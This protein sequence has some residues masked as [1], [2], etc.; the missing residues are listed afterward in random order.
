MPAAIATRVKELIRDVPGF[1]EPDVVFRDLTPVLGDPDAFKAV[2][3][4]M[5]ESLAPVKPHRVAGVEARGFLFAAP[6]ALALGAGVIPV[7]KAG[8]LPWD[9]AAVSYD[10]EYGSDTLEAHVD[11]VAPGETVAVIDDVLATGGTARAT[12]ELLEK[13]GAR[14]AALAFVL[15]LAPLGGRSR[16]DRWETATMVRYE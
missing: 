16:L 12:A 4:W 5:A 6:V 9:V 15:E 14:V 2:V 10:L 1:P 11:A 7:R 13:L 3:D 8:K